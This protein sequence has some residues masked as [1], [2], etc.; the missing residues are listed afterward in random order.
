MNTRKI[1]SFIS[2]A[3]VLVACERTYS[4]SLDKVIKVGAEDFTEIQLPEL[5]K[6]DIEEIGI[7]GIGIQDSLLFVTTSGDGDLL[8]I[9]SARDFSKIGDYLKKGRGP[10]ELQIP[11]SM[12][13]VCFGKDNDDLVL[14]FRD[15]MSSNLLKMDVTKSI[16][17]GRA[18]LDT[19]GK[20]KVE[21]GSLLKTDVIDDNTYFG[22]KL[23]AACDRQERFLMR[24]G[25]EYVTPAMEKLNSYKIASPDRAQNFNL[26]SA[27]SGCHKGEVVEAMGFV[28]SVQVYPLEGEGGF[29]ICYGKKLIDT[30]SLEKDFNPVTK[31][32]HAGLSL[33]DNYFTTQYVEDVDGDRKLNMLQIY[34]WEGKPLYSIALP[35]DVSGYDMDSSTGELFLVR[36]KD[37]C[38]YHCNI[39][40]L[41]M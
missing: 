13:Q 9:Y 36:G 8:H 2:I 6:V 31:K 7:L 17:E 29:T 3:L 4:P 24:N 30:H 22:K 28:N 1:L 20:A 39:P 11:F 41:K 37:D 38:I 10:G 35:S 18:A 12:S 27:V 5:Q 40:E 33:K 16:E 32:G 14:R 19:L 26:F 15:Y 34:T 25:R 23:P 21:G